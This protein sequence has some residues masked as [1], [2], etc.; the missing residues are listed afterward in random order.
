LG[1]AGATLRHCLHDLLCARQVLI[2][3][4]NVSM[5]SFFVF[6]AKGPVYIELRT[7]TLNCS[8][9]ALST[10]LQ[11]GRTIPRLRKLRFNTS[12]TRARG[13]CL[14]RETGPL[15]KAVQ[16]NGVLDGLCVSVDSLEL[17]QDWRCR[18]STGRRTKRSK[19][20]TYFGGQAFQCLSDDFLLG[21]T[22]Q[23]MAPRM[24]T[25]GLSS[26]CACVLKLRG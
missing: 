10:I 22:S 9:C 25:R 18:Q 13:P 16:A 2:G 14:M 23:A 26:Q 19:E 4:R 7:K 21:S 20:F 24:L 6:L 8:Q 5:E 12:Q 11:S 17:V 15:V 1:T 3:G